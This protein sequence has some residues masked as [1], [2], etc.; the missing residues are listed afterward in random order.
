MRSWGEGGRV[1]PEVEAG[2]LSSAFEAELSVKESAIILYTR[3]VAT[4]THYNHGGD[5]VTD[6]KQVAMYI[7]SLQQQ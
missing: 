5:V 1:G 4:F 7:H 2:P 6:T 3:E